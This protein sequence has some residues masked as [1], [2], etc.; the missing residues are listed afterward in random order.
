MRLYRL[1]G[2]SIKGMRRFPLART[3]ARWLWRGGHRL[4]WDTLRKLVPRSS[5]F[6]PA[7]GTFSA[8][9]LLQQGRL[10][11]RLL[12]P[13]QPNPKRGPAP[14]RAL[15]GMTQDQIGSWPVFWTRH[16][17]ARLVGQTLVVQDERKRICFEAAYGDYGI[18][19]D[20]AF[21]YFFLA[22]PLRL[23]GNWT[24]LIS[25]WSTGFY[26]WFMDALPRLALLREFPADTRVLVPARLA[27]YQEQ[28]LAWLG[29]EKRHR[30]THERH[31][32]IEN[33]FFSSPTAMTGC[34]DAVSIGFLRESFLKHADLFYTPPRRF[35][36]QRVGQSRGII[37]EPE[38]LDFFRNKGWAIVAME[39]LTLGQQIRLFSE[40]EAICTLHGAAL[41]NLV[42]CKPGCRV[43]ELVADTFINGVYEGIAEQV[44]VEH[45]FLLCP[46][47]LA[48][49]ARV[50]IGRLG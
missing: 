2:N 22:P 43:L 45:R 3:L 49:R 6:G 28:T 25:Q 17:Q 46:G 18:E 16:L 33:Y 35:Y 29:L 47:D 36:I 30:P 5:R 15:A 38:V 9:E 31:L 1:T 34:Y 8:L 12:L 21:N 50:D 14:L 7:K 27:P 4:F 42:W 32:L 44:G 26:H 40:A 13:A 41:T 23:D 10:E 48:F 20:P 39:N 19:S 37:N 11:G 24:S